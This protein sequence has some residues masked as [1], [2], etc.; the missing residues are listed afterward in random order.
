LGVIRLKNH[1]GKKEEE[2]V[3]METFSGEG[4]FLGHV[5]NRVY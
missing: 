2:K 3:Y 1:D 4:I 5:E